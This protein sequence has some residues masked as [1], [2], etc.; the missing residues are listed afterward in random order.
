MSRNKSEG[1]YVGC[2][3]G[4][5]VR[6]IPEE[7]K[8]EGFWK[9]IFGETSWSNVCWPSSDGA[10]IIMYRKRGVGY[11]VYRTRYEGK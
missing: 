4:K 8:N 10:W 9:E 3:R 6:D 2:I 1:Q 11:A 7:Y 5:H